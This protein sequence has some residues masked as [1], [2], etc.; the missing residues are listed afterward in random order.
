M[1]LPPRF[2]AQ[3]PAGRF[4][5]KI[6]NGDYI[7]IGATN[8][9]VQISYNR[10]SNSAHL[11][12]LGTERGGCEVTGLGTD[13]VTMTDFGFTIL[14]Q[15]YPNVNPIIELRD[16]AKF[17]CNIPGNNRTSITVSEYNLLLAG[18]TYYQDRFDAIPKYPESQTAYENFYRA[19]TDP[20]KFDKNY[21]FRNDDLNKLLGPLM[22][23][24]NTWAEFFSKFY[25]KYKRKACVLMHSWYRDV[26][27]SLA[28]QALHADWLI[29]ISGRPVIE[30]TIISRNITNRN[31]NNYTRRVLEY[32]P[33]EFSGG[34]YNV[35]S[36]GYRKFV[37][38][39]GVGSRRIS[40]KKQIEYLNN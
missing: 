38:R 10:R 14:K 18:K 37:R 1:D 36:I 20:A 4:K 7:N 22:Q 16:S 23:A 2:E 19:W 13:T 3:T 8:F 12:W 25:A 30:Y 29:D 15:L 17:T 24:S 26:Y 27:G 35:R 33:Y 5:V 40:R 28:R 6:T 39:G 34:R 31:T 11:E 32:N 9:C 21:D